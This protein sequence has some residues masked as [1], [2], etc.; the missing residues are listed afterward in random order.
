VAK[1]VHLRIDLMHHA[2]RV[3]PGSRFDLLPGA[4]LD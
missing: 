4:R 1:G 2:L 3:S